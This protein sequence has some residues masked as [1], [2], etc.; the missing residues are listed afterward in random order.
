M[1]G[2]EE[3]AK[4]LGPLAA[5][6]IG[7]GTMIGAGIF[8]LPGTA[9]ARAGPLAA[10]TFVL[11]GIIA[12]FTALSASELGT[13]MPKSGGAY[14]YVNRAL[15]PLFGSIAGWANWLGLAF[16]SAFYM[17]GFGEYV[18]ALVGLGPVGLGPVTLEAA[19]VIG[20]AGALLFI[21]VNYFGA[22]ETGGL[23][24]VIV[25]SLLGILAV[26]TVVGLLNADMESLRPFAPPGTT[27][28]VLPVTGIIFVSYLGF[29]QITSVAEEIKN[30]G[31]NLP[32]AVL[33]SVVIVTVVYA[34]FLV[35]LLAAV[36]NELVANNETAVVD[37]ARLLFG[38]YAVFGY[39]LG[40]VGAGMLLVG[41]LLATASSANASILSSSR[42]N[43]AMGREK[44]VTPTLNEIHDRFGTPYKSIALTGGLI[45]VFLLAGGVESLSTMGS[46]L[47]LIVYG[48]LN[49]A[50][51]VMR[52][53]GVE[54]YDPDFEVPFY[55]FV[56]IIGTISSFALIVYID[57]TIILFSA[58]LVA[59]ATVWYLV[60]AR[61]KV[62]ARGVL[63]S[64][65]LDRSDT[66]PKPAVSAATSVQ[67][68]GGDYRV[69]VPL[70]NPATEEHLITLASAIAK[71]R[72][73]TVVAVNI[74]NVPDQTSLEAARDRGAHDAARDLL[75]RAK[76]D[77]ETFD[78]DVETH[79]V[80]SHRVFEEVFDAAR[81][82]GADLTVMGWGEDSH[83]AP[84]RAESAVDEL[85]YALPSD[86]LVFR[87]RG[88]DPSRILVPTAG[89]P[90]SDLSAAVAKMLQVEFDGEITLL[91][92][93]DDE[94]AGREFLTGWADA[95]GLSDATLRIE[96]GD[97][98]ASIE[99]AARDATLLIVGATEK[100]LLSR[101]VRGSLVLQVLED[102]E[103]SVLLAEK[104]SDR[105]LLGRLFGGGTDTVEGE[106]AADTGV[107]TDPST[108]GVD[109]DGR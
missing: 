96:S 61:E 17:Y 101:L 11:G 4:D 25:M 97:V 15:G 36:P 108:P 78:V 16:A 41:G 75:D 22:K 71:Q 92:V 68:S 67:P 98:E 30:P 27:S 63:G 45:L 107:G 102:V 50:L 26:F 77:A 64:W 105:G 1:S 2:D 10:L 5:L 69:M 47:H 99:R 46:V 90:A 73:G 42:I 34:L 49:L 19:Q 109:D 100:G 29:V 54:G 24:I 52:E 79:V 56:P 87:D 43:F 74:A 44:I 83:G 39:S 14:F 13:A 12:L 23:Q 28:Q 104:R 37:A 21:A 82:Y 70:A 95:H 57:P 3:L 9:V 6:T 80:L 88:F 38:N 8:V 66:L 59:F 31:R 86:F 84:G 106:T 53:S 40:A 94:A 7:I 72:D 35:V 18:N 48:L 65:V 33:G 20:F 60:Y 58:G 89:G 103:C 62:T 32:L 81:T 91:H 85:A 93:A 51:I 76:D 55:P